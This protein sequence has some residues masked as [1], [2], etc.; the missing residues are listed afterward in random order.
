[1]QTGSFQWMKSLNK[2]IILNKILNNGPISRAQIAKET[3][4]TPPTVGSIV[5]ELMEQEIVEESAQGTSQ[6]GRKPTMLVINHR[7]FYVVGVDAGPKEIEC[8]LTDL[9]GKT[10][11]HF[12]SGIT[13][14]ISKEEFLETLNRCIHHLLEPHQ[15]LKEKVIGIGVAMHGVVDVATG[16]AL[17]APN[18]HLRDV[19]IKA[20][21]EKEFN[22]AV[23]VENDA[24]ALALGEVWFGQGKESES[25]IAVNI[26]NGVGAGIAIKGKL[27]HGNADIA[28]EIGH[29][30]IDL[31]GKQ[32][33]C[34]NKGCLQTVVSGPGIAE[35]AIEG[36]DNG[37][38][39][40][41]QII[42]DQGETVTG[43]MVHHVAQGGDTFAQQLLEEIGE[44]IGVGLTNLIHVINPS[45]II[46]GGG[47][48]KA[49]DFI[50]EPIQ[51]TIK[52]R[53][54]TEQAKQTKVVLS[55]LGD[56]ATALGAVS[57][58]LAELFERNGEIKV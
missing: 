4:L 24:R 33:E 51:N 35:R 7:G 29:M 30:T 37:E 6:G 52:Q 48:S 3:N 5:K 41:L 2:S 49:G 38:K 11:S 20:A 22:Y 13:L 54:I 42:R 58:L 25:M 15:K 27:Y 8:I 45:K 53:A 1:M 21:L 43:A 14:P 56:Q 23:K 55:N 34:G 39:S 57:L 9:S 12:I 18:L 32:C 36:L 19:P 44:Y 46:I 47:V 50:L 16:T 26:G 28:G 31:H 40:K 17:F 10:I